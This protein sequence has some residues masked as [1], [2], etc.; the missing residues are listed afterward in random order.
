MPRIRTVKPEFWTDAKSGQLDDFTKCFFLGLLNHADDSGVLQWAPG[1]WAVKIA[2][3]RE[4]SRTKIVHALID[5]IDKGMVRMFGY[6]EEDVGE[7]KVYLFITNFSKHQVINRP[8][9]PVIKGWRIG[10]TPESFAKRRNCALSEPSLSD[11]GALTVGKEGK[12]TKK[13]R[14]LE[15]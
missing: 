1:E 15:K 9:H 14:I 6:S 11:H 8:S 13:E 4:D 3:Y 10:D 12:G 2:P 7:Y 5:L